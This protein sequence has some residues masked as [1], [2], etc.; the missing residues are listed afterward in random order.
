MVGQAVVEEESQ[1]KEVEYRKLLSDDVTQLKKVAQNR[2]LLGTGG[3]NILKK[4][5]S[6]EQIRFFCHKPGHG[7][8]VHIRTK[9]NVNG[10]AVVDLMLE[11]SK[12]RPP[13]CNSFE[14]FPDDNSNIG[15]NCSKWFG[16][17]WYDDG[18]RARG[19]KM[20]ADPM[21][22]ANRYYFS[23]APSGWIECDDFVNDRKHGYS[24]VGRWAF[25]VR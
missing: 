1:R 18:E 17:I 4:Y 15:N 22:I 8:S 11:K 21:V 13:S 25:Y 9:T 7:R 23:L 12:V 20:Y 6:F 19:A 14:T 16:K 3:L 24:S 2:F 5:I 10:K